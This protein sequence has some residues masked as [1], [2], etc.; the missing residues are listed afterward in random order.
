ME[1]LSQPGLLSASTK[2]PLHK[3]GASAALG[4]SGKGLRCPLGVSIL[5]LI[6]D[7]FAQGRKIN[8]DQ[9]GEVEEKPSSYQ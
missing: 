8:L 1:H 4:V 6:I 7:K 9:W 3:P 5:M 2:I